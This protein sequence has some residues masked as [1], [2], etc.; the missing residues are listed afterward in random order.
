MADYRTLFGKRVKALRKSR[1]LTQA[2]LAEK[3]EF[4]INYISQI[5][6][7]EASPTFNTILKLAQGLAVEP[8]ELFYFSRAKED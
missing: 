5:E 6:T 2:Q 4:S 1:G 3:L 7:G 8:I